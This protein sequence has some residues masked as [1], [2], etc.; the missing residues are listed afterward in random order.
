MPSPNRNRNPAPGRYEYRLDL[1][2]WKAACERNELHND[3]DAALHL[4]LVT[5]TI[6]RV[7]A[8]TTRPSNVFMAHVRFYWPDEKFDDLFRLTKVA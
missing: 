8:G 2:A 1:L 5:S 7:R 6:C 3:L 4:H